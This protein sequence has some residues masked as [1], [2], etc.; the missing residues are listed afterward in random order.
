MGVVVATP[1][2][3]KT[4]P[5]SRIRLESPEKAHAAIAA[6]AREGDHLRVFA[7]LDRKTRWS[8][9][10]C[11]RDKRSTYRLVSAHYPE[12]RRAAELR[13][14]ARAQKAA[15]APSYFA[16][17][18]RGEKL[19]D[20]LK[21]APARAKRAGSGASRVEL[22]A[23][24]QRFAYCREVEGWAFCGLRERLSKMQLRA[25]RDLVSVRESAETYRR[26]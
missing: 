3:C 16:A 10:S 26:E 11:Y 12:A 17:L 19:L 1:C 8:V 5:T 2:G 6:A 20:A 24:G 18:A 14:V 23:G 25:A 7:M 13:R 9:M 15:D 4:R 22:V 21:T